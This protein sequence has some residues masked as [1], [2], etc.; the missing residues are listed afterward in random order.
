[1]AS[2]YELQTKIV[3]HSFGELMLYH[4]HGFLECCKVISK[5]HDTEDACVASYEVVKPIIDYVLEK[6][7]GL[8]TYADDIRKCVQQ[9]K[10]KQYGS[11]REVF[12]VLLRDYNE[13]KVCW[14]VVKF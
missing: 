9:I 5:H 7:V 4:P 1:M 2:G 3:Y 10:R 13:D 6:G 12:D 11:P 14:N 8:P